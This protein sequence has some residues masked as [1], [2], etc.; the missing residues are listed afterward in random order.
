MKKKYIAPKIDIKHPHAANIVCASGDDGDG[1]ISARNRVQ[2]D[3]DD[4]DE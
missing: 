3:W 1:E 2:D 4:D